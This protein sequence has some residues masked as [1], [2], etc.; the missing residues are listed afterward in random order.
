MP[1][2]AGPLGPLTG[3]A[4][5]LTKSM[6]AEPHS[7]FG[8]GRHIPLEGGFT[9]VV[10]D[11]TL[12]F[13]V[14][15]GVWAPTWQ[16]CTLTYR[17]QDDHGNDLEHMDDIPA[18][19]RLEDFQPLIAEQEVGL[20]RYVRYE[21]TVELPHNEDPSVMQPHSVY[22]FPHRPGNPLAVL[23]LGAHDEGG[24]CGSCSHVNPNKPK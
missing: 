12:I 5:N 9:L 15:S 20:R 6:P 16:T 24:M 14:T 10:E 21:G 19:L 13:T 3:M 2:D 18:G 22:L 7:L 23:V 8:G 11:G 4:L 17:T 1:N